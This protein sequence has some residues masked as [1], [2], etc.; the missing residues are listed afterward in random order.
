[1]SPNIEASQLDDEILKA[2][3]LAANGQLEEAEVAYSTL[4]QLHPEEPRVLSTLGTLLFWKGR[5]V[6]ARELIEKSLEI[7]PEQPKSLLNLS[8]I[9]FNLGDLDA[10][11]K[12]ADRSLA[13]GDPLSEA[14]N[15]RG[16]IL[17]AQGRFNEAL[18][19]LDRALALDP[20]NV[21]ALYNKGT[22]L[23][24]LEQIDSAFECYREV[25]SRNP[26][27]IGAHYN[28]AVL[29]GNHGSHQQALAYLSNAIALRPH[30]DDALLQRARLFM[31]LGR[32]TEALSDTE[33]VL[34]RSPEHPAALF[35]HGAALLESGDA[36]SALVYLA[37]ARKNAPGDVPTLLAIG[38][39]H[40]ELKEFERSLEAFDAVIALDPTL[41]EAHNNKGLVLQDTHLHAAAIDCYQRALEL[42]PEFPDA[43][44]NYANA[45]REQGAFEDALALYERLL[46]IAPEHLKNHK[47]LKNKGATLE[48]MKRYE[49]ALAAFNEAIS[50]APEDAD[51]YVNAT[52]VLIRLNRVEQ[53]IGYTNK[54]LK[55]NPKNTDAIYLR[56]S[57]LLKLDLK[58]HAR[59]EIETALA[60]DPRHALSNHLMGKLHDDQKHY[61]EALSHYEI[62]YA[63]N[64]TLDFLVGRI[65]QLRALICDWRTHQETND[66]MLTLIEQGKTA[67]HPFDLHSKVDAPEHHR[68]CAEIFFDTIA[69]TDVAPPLPQRPENSRIHVAYF[70]SDIGNHPVS[71]LMAGVFE[72]H[73]RKDFEITLFSLEN[74]TGTT[75]NRIFSS[76]ERAINAEFMTDDE[77]VDLAR[78]LKIDIAVDLNGYTSKNR[79]GIFIK[80][81]AP[82]QI[83][84]I[85]YLGTMGSDCHDYIIGDAT[86]SPLAHESYFTEK[87]IQLPCYQANDDKVTIPETTKTR[88]DVGLPENA[89]V[90]C[91]FNSNYKI[92]PPIFTAWM[93]ILHQVPDS[94]LWL[95]C[96]RDD[97]ISRNLQA[98]AV[99]HGISAERLI[100]APGVPYLKHLAR[101]R[102]ADLFLDTFPYNAGATASNAL[103]SGLPLITYCGK[104]FCSRYGASLLTALN[105]QELITESIDDYIAL[106]VRLARDRSLLADVKGKLARN[107]K[108]G[109][110]FNTRAFT[111]NLEQAY[112]AI[113][114]RHRNGLKP[115]HIIVSGEPKK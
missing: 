27:H 48:K 108:E 85:G 12:A 8:A 81:A 72:A 33:N 59:T 77:V 68:K 15:N 56:A 55:L 106:S 87:I 16:V 44:Y 112:R 61:S 38:V 54:A 30:F 22:V 114:T 2:R 57:Q 74:H 69:S 11:L 21:E 82:I 64:P 92:T 63:E 10:A 39:A 41:P 1:M 26:N 102:L 52:N 9:L 91:S 86:I 79:T 105:L 94:V 73:N 111:E 20:N 104:S 46:V 7:N 40:Y 49:D 110:L 83:N 13:Q 3:T 97:V 47:G 42:R 101:H 24:A 76:C 95:H 18:R 19:D 58:T 75:R 65:A 78:S 67:C 51:A 60:I 89:F 45:L 29:L 17:N 62:A 5:F 70:S 4:L 43:L 66:K 90:F 109:P 31:Q 32:F 100:I 36:E 71:Y 115:D 28:S 103:Y 6:E 96:K 14:W 37:R 80:R 53:A 84:Y 35:H 23:Q 50:L 113:H 93:S 25:L 98:A 107:V 88:A 99:A 34:S